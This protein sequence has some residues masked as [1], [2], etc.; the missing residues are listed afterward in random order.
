MRH[1]RPVLVEHLAQLVHHRRHR[2][3]PGRTGQLLGV[4]ADQP[5]DGERQ[6]VGGHLGL[7]ANPPVLHHFGV[8]ARTR[9][10]P[11]DGVGVADVDG[12]QHYRGDIS[13]A[14][15]AGTNAGS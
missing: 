3:Q 10:Q 15:S 13:S 7:G 11:D 4:V 5:V 8:V 9:H 14:A 12:D 2:R 1:R 6:F